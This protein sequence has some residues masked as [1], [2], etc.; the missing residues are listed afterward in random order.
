MHNLAH[1]RR[2]GPDPPG[3]K[4]RLPKGRSAIFAPAP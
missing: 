4:D 2:Y 3:M 1:G